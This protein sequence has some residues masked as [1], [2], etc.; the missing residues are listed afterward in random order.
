MCHS[1]RLSRGPSAR[2]QHGSGSGPVAARG[3]GLR[4]PSWSGGWR[5]RCASG[6]ARLGLALGSSVWD[7]SRDCGV[8][9]RR[10]KYAVV[11]LFSNYSPHGTPT[12]SAHSAATAELN[13]P[14]DARPHYV[15]CRALTLSAKQHERRD[16]P[17]QGLRTPPGLTAAAPSFIH[18]YPLNLKLR[19]LHPARAAGTLQPH[20]PATWP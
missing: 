6:A 10:I 11:L 13:N 7:G 3:S 12:P 18:A 4:A 5:L 16:S 14:I 8:G 15:Q 2:Q 9:A 20:Q 19:A 17:P 1:T